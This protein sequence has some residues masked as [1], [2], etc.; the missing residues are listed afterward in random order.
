MAAGISSGELGELLDRAD[1]NAA[2]SM[3]LIEAH[4]GIH[5][6]HEVDAKLQLLYG[7][8]RDIL[9]GREAMAAEY[10]KSE[11]K[12]T[13]KGRA[14]E[15]QDCYRAV[16]TALENPD[17]TGSER[18]QLA[19]AKARMLHQAFR[20]SLH[21]IRRVIGK[22]VGAWR[23]DPI[24][25]AQ[26]LV[27]KYKGVDRAIK[28]LAEVLNNDWRFTGMELVRTGD[29][30]KI[31]AIDGPHGVSASV[32]FDKS[33]ENF[34][35]VLQHM[36]HLR[37]EAAKDGQEPPIVSTSKVSSLAHNLAALLHRREQEMDIKGCAM[38]QEQ[39]HVAIAEG[40]VVW[41][42][43]TTISAE[44]Q[45]K[46]VIHD[47][48]A[49]Q[50]FV[51]HDGK[52]LI[53]RSSRTDSVQRIQKKS[54]GDIATR[55]RLAIERL[56]DR[57]G[58]DFDMRDLTYAQWREVGGTDSAL[59]PVFDE[60]GQLTHFIYRRVDCTFLDKS[61]S[62]AVATTL[63]S[64][65]GALFRRIGG[66]KVALENESHFLGNKRDSIEEIWDESS[67]PT[68][69][70][71]QPY[72]VHQ[73]HSCPG[74]P[75]HEYEPIMLNFAFSNQ[76]ER[77]SQVDEARIANMM[78]VSELA[79]EALHLLPEC[80]AKTELGVMILNAE[81]MEPTRWHTAVESMATRLPEL[82][83]QRF[84]AAFRGVYVMLECDPHTELLDMDSVASSRIQYQST[85]LL[86][87][88]AGYAMGVEC[89]SGNDRTA[90]GVALRCAQKA[91]EKISG[92]VYDFIDGSAIDRKV[93]SALFMGY[94]AGFGI[95]NVEVSR[96]EYHN[97]GKSALKIGNSCMA[98]DLL[99]VDYLSQLREWVEITNYSEDEHQKRL[100]ELAEND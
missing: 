15:F 97:S 69:D 61:R 98:M 18:Q 33:V 89:K 36:R 84:T 28:A 92:R 56:R 91:F 16:K 79:T 99:T 7:R 71:G 29:Y 75:V 80:P 17:I 77:A 21:C 9:S 11:L 8:L 44:L 60:N 85:C 50:G 53:A 24:R 54:A 82:K 27:D 39:G 95:P 52:V 59:T 78:G 22:S 72:Y 73:I 58:D 1:V 13:L 88:L 55:I 90:T 25:V 100:D 68:D 93:Y 23:T 10:S 43:G 65:P 63:A 41:K 6:K 48:I 20:Y 81:E 67:A 38:R 42:S 96:G 5:R 46:R 57:Y 86:A 32:D 66:K 2:V 51:E 64:L 14:T 87:E 70:R 19:E 45:K 26:Y 12:R 35:L 76:A 83:A 4:Q 47:V 3:A 49:N 37:E 94:L 62:K 34:K 31:I 74:I 40:R 30:W